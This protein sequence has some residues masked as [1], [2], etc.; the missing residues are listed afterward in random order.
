MVLQFHLRY[1]AH[2]DGSST[3]TWVYDR[4]QIA[5]HYIRG[6]FLIDFVSLFT[7][8]FDL[9]PLAFSKLAQIRALSFSFTMLKASLKWI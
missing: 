1:E 4:R 6:A 3:A 7:L 5:L 9:L 8:I 2:V